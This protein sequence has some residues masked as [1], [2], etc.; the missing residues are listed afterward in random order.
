MK[1][2]RPFTSHSIGLVSRSPAFFLLQTCA[3]G[4]GVLV[5]FA[6][7]VREIV[8]PDWPKCTSTYQR[9]TLRNFKKFDQ[10]FEY[11]R[12]PVTGLD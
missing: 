5:H 10:R 7:Q 3:D 4:Y 9:E 2:T 1:S 8:E 12:R 11:H 6:L